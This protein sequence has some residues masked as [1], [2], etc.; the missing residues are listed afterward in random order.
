MR[1]FPSACN[2]WWLRSQSVKSEVIGAAHCRSSLLCTAWYQRHKLC[3]TAGI[4]VKVS[5]VTGAFLN[6]QRFDEC[7]YSQQEDDDLDFDDEG[8]LYSR[9]LAKL[10]SLPMRIWGQRCLH[11]TLEAS[12]SFTM[13]LT[14]EMIETETQIPIFRERFYPTV[15]AERW[16]FEK[17]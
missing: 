9:G 17:F 7:F 10:K 5:E 4:L 12:L 8:F 3:K 16:V 1:Y 2:H 11:L 13:S 6:C 15:E 14:Q